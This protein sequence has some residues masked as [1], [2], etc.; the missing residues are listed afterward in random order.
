MKSYMGKKKAIIGIFIAITFMLVSMVGACLVQTSWGTVEV[1]DLRFE[2]S[3]GYEMSALLYKPKTA[4]TES[5][6]PA[7]ITCHGMYNNRE[8]QDINMVELSRR[9]FVVLSIDMFSHGNSENLKTEDAL[10]MGVTEALKMLVNLSYVDTERI[11][12]TGHSMGGLNC[13]IATLMDNQNSQ[14]YVSA[15]LLNSCFATYKDTETD[16][17]VNVYGGRDVG[18]IAGQYDEFLFQEVNEDGTKLLAKDFIKSDNAQSFLNFGAEPV[19]GE[20]LKANVMYKENVNGE[21]AVRVIYNPAIT[22]PWSHFSKRSATATIEFFDASLTAPNSISADNQIWQLKEIFNAVGLV[23][24]A[25]FVMYTMI[26][27]SR[28]SLFESIVVKKNEDL[29]RTS[30]KRRIWNYGII[31][32]NVIFCT[33]T[34]L[35]IVTGVKSDNNG[36]LLFSQNTSFG[37]GLWAALCGAF[38]L[39]CMILSKI[40]CK[41]EE[42]IGL[43]ESGLLL[44]RRKLVMTVIAGG[45]TAILAYTWVEI[46]NYFFHTDFRVWVLA[47]KTITAEKVWIILFPNLLLFLIFYV[48][49]AISVNSFF[50][51]GETDDKRKEAGQTALMAFISVLPPM[52]LVATQYIHLFTTGKVLFEVN[53]AHSMILW[54]FPMIILIPT[55]VI[56]SRKVYKETHNAYLPGIVNAIL[57]TWITCANT[58]TWG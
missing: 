20:L 57:I 12:L 50:T 52:L 8:M 43:K 37:I 21:E 34:Y 16:D 56:V 53:N 26:L 49:N 2:T 27:L 17:Y 23:G 32:A 18:I 13:N 19:Q 24:L 30:K 9:G 29:V 54:L 47:A 38:L 14:Q 35:P 33:I 55:A 58:S 41:K 15:L 44:E 3:M 28:T 36:K 46:A 5:K 40:A 42:S 39:F 6:A 1:K 25:L 22:H 48:V 31:I 7:I 45:I 11:G 10:P 4:T 51:S